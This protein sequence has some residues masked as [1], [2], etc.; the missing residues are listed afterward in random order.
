MQLKAYFTKIAAALALT[1][2]VR[3]ILVVLQG[4]TAARVG[5]AVIAA[6][7][8]LRLPMAR[9]VVVR[10]DKYA[11]VIPGSSARMQDIRHARTTIFVA[12]SL[13]TKIDP[14]DFKLISSSL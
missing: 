5:V 3:E 6:N 13:S 11:P 2:D 10:M 8:V 4:P 1:L 12:V 9:V 7:I 14:S